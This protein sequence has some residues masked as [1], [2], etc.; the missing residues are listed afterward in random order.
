MVCL[1]CVGL[2]FYDP[3]LHTP[4]FS[5]RPAWTGAS[6]ARTQW[7][8][9]SG[10]AHSHALVICTVACPLVMHVYPIYS[11]AGA[12]LTQMYGVRLPRLYAHN[13][14]ASS[15]QRTTHISPM[16][17][18]AGCERGIGHRLLIAHAYSMSCG[19]F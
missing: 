11:S 6:V 7:A 17:C 13:S 10:P 3:S 2:W 5:A 12:T 9:A 16:Q 15:E 14:S 8:P 4:G 19:G 18:S 1:L